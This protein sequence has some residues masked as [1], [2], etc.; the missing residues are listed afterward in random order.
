MPPGLPVPRAVLHL[1]N[2]RH[3]FAVSWVSDLDVPAQ[4]GQR[5]AYDIQPPV[6]RRQPASYVAVPSASS[7]ST[8]SVT[9]LEEEC[10]K[11][12]EVQPAPRAQPRTLLVAAATS[13]LL[14]VVAMVVLRALRFHLPSSRRAGVLGAAALVA[15]LA[16]A[17]ASLASVGL[18]VFLQTP[19]IDRTGSCLRSALEPLLSSLCPRRVSSPVPF[20]YYSDFS[21]RPLRPVSLAASALFSSCTC[22]SP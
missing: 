20:S 6:Q 12:L 1:A 15:P 13:A 10:D 18:C 17:V 19:V 2:S 22:F 8:T 3:P 5:L 9:P 16:V 4:G 7:V 21:R 11:R 14:V